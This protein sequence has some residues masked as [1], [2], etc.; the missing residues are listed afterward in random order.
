MLMEEGFNDP[1]PRQIF[2]EDM[3]TLISTINKNPEN[4]IILMLDAKENL[5][6]SE[7]GF[8]KLLH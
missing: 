1:N 4:F 8:S 7:G 5:N 6:D 2:I 3:I